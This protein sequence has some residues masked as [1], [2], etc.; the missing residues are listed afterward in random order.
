[1]VVGNSLIMAEGKE[2]RAKVELTT[3]REGIIRVGPS[4]AW[5]EGCEG[6]GWSHHILHSLLVSK[7]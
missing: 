3:N 2:N 7:C 5:D 1:M 4:K 6:V